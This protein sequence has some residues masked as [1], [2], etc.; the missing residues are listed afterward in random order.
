M[1]LSPEVAQ[2]L[3]EERNAA[4]DELR[5]LIRARDDDAD[6][7]EATTR[8]HIHLVRRIAI[9]DAARSGYGFSALT[10]AE[11]AWL[12]GQGVPTE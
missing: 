8:Q 6:F 11:L 10:A 12:R 2:R 5:A 9:I 4:C 3:I 1:S 7:T